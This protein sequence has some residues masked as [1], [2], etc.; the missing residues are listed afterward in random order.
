MKV[1]E[2]R[3]QIRILEQR[4]RTHEDTTLLLE[5]YSELADRKL[6]ESEKG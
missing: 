6:F 4:E 2:L 5:L 1:N 3:Q